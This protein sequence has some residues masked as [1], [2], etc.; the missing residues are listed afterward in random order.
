MTIPSRWTE[1]SSPIRPAIETG[2]TLS[3]P[4]SSNSAGESAWPEAESKNY[5]RPFWKTSRWLKAC[6]AGFFLDGRGRRSYLLAYH[7]RRNNLN[8]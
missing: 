3:K 1:D 8:G 2:F 5:S 7:T 4:I 6:C